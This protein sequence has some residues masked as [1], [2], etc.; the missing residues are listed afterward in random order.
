M[1]F[2]ERIENLLYAAK[3]VLFFFKDL[4]N[5]EYFVFA[6]KEIK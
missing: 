4:I 1:A 3:M 5:R 6:D 2:L